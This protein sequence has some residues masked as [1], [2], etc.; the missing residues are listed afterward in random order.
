MG[1]VLAGRIA[2]ARLAGLV[3]RTPADLEQV[4]G[5]GPM[6]SA[7][8]APLV[9]FASDSLKTGSRAP[10]GTLPADTTAVRADSLSDTR[11]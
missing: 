7:R 5:I 9:I 8:L 3:F 6:L 10:S 11:R 4:K 2:E 1:P